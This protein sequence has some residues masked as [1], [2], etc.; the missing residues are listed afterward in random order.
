MRTFGLY[1]ILLLFIMPN[2]SDAQRW[3][4][5]RYEILGGIGTANVF[6]DLGGGAGEAR[7]NVA[8]MDLQATGVSLMIAGRYKIKELFALKVNVIYAFAR[9]SDDYT[10]NLPRSN[11]GATSTISLIEPSFQLE[12][13]I[14]KERYS[15]RYSYS[16]IRHF[17]FNHI[18]TYLFVGIGGVLSFPNKEIVVDTDI[19]EDAGAFA[20]AFPMGI[21]FKY[22][23]N[24]V[25]TVGL[26][27]GHRF[28]TTDYL[29][30]HSDKYS[31]AN[32]SYMF[33]MISVSKRLRT[34]RKGLPRF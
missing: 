30:G 15:R 7:H 26:E 25:Y 9:A 21:G 11:R 17:R 28:T 31:Q 24:R 16:N 13:S 23:I 1:I 18:N 34:S 4:R 6:G 32:D 2:T 10:T 14:I 8:D 3:R 12:Y 29:E 22:A 27:L 33:L 19:G 20:A 5:Y